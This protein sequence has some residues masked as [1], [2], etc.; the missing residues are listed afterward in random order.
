MNL[1]VWPVKDPAEKFTLSFDY[2]AALASGET[3]ISAAIAVSVKAGVDATPNNFLD[4]VNQVLA[5]V[6]L[7]GI[8]D[9]IDQ[10]S[11]LVRC[12]ATLS[13]GRV[14]VLAGVVPV[15]VLG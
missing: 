5:G 13:S 10:A 11:Y 6:V 1:N 4:G 3:I 9:G 15:R 8:K 7:Q 14:L 2:T 12:V